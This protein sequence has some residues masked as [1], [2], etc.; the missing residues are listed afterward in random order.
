[1]KITYH[2]RFIGGSLIVEFGIAARGSRAAGTQSQTQSFIKKF[3]QSCP[4][5]YG[6]AFVLYEHVYGPYGFWLAGRLHVAVVLSLRGLP[7]RFYSQGL[8]FQ[9]L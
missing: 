6:R 2:L 5:P 1:M 9:P 8:F 7:P 3:I 4:I